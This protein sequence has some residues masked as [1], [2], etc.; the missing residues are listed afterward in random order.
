MKS[1][2]ILQEIL[3]RVG[4]KL[5]L[6]YVEFVGEEFRCD[7]ID[8]KSGCYVSQVYRQK[9]KRIYENEEFVKY[10]DVYNWIGFF[11]V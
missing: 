7:I 3:I 5:L 8:I 4:V 9:L 1:Y 11:L 6:Y 2:Q 10:F